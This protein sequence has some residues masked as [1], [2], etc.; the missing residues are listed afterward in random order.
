MIT[1]SLLAVR[2]AVQHFL[3]ELVQCESPPPGPSP[4]ATPG[5]TGSSCGW[6]PT[7]A[8]TASARAPPTRSP[9]RSRRRSTSSRHVHR[10]RPDT[11]RAA[12]RAHAP[13][14]VHG[15]RPDPRAALAAIEI[16]CWDILGKASA[17]RCMRSS[18]AGC[19]TASASTRTAG[20]RSSARPRP[21]RRRHG[22]SSRRATRRSSSTRSATPRACRPRRG[23]AR[24]RPHPGGPRRDRPGVDLL[25]EGHCRFGVA[26]GD[27][28]RAAD[29]ALEPALVRGAGSHHDVDSVVEVARHSPVPIAAIRGAAATPGRVRI[30]EDMRSASGREGRLHRGESRR[31]HAQ[32]AGQPQQPQRC[33]G[34]LAPRLRWPVELAR[35]KA[36]PGESNIATRA[37]KSTT[38]KH[39]GPQRKSRVRRTDLPADPF[40]QGNSWKSRGITAPQIQE[41]HQHGPD[42]DS[43]L[44][45]HER[46]GEE[47]GVREMK[48]SGLPSGRRWLQI[49]SHQPYG[50]E[51]RQQLRSAIARYDRL[52]VDR[53]HREQ[54]AAHAATARPHNR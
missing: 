41:Q 21:W 54:L 23:G 6:T 50:K 47:D 49:S 15:R 25:I 33:E 24:D 38:Q 27:P 26:A 13:R 3:E 14:R 11:G 44:F 1:V 32:F 37:P 45:A 22:P 31:P 10:A 53:M 48:P 7:R 36:P 9:G 39:R 18:A 8:S 30:A 40:A 35:W 17:C 29:G 16:A 42:K 2:A 19:A 52:G 5:R 46:R 20:T 12:P 34:A 4:S 43:V 28:L 51:S